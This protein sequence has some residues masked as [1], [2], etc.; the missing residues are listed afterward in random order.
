MVN[1]HLQKY[2]PHSWVMEYV[3]W[4]TALTMKKK[5]QHLQG[6]TGTR[7]SERQ[8]MVIMSVIAHMYRAPLR[9]NKIVCCAWTVVQDMCA[10][11]IFKFTSLTV[12][13]LD[14]A[15]QQDAHFFVRGHYSKSQLIGGAL[16]HWVYYF[17][18]FV[19]SLVE[20][21]LRR[22]CFCSVERGPPLCGCAYMR[23]RTQQQ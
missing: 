6:W 9:M 8:Q 15:K 22:L 2:M 3:A 1:P 21:L 23:V 19:V 14:E 7:P 20:G 13:V 12:C 11:W 16:Q 5:V 17:W 18:N 4:N 10:E